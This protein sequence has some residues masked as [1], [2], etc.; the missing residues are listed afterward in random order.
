MHQ[1]RIVI[2]APAPEPVG[3]LCAALTA[4]GVRCT[5]RRILGTQ[6]CRVHAVA[7]P[8]AGIVYRADPPFRIPPPVNALRCTA[9]THKGHRCKLYRALVG[10]GGDLFCAAHARGGARV[11]RAVPIGDVGRFAADTQNVHTRE[12]AEMV[13]R[14]AAE[15]VERATTMK[16]I[17][18]AF[19]KL[20]ASKHRHRRVTVLADMREW[21]GKS[22]VRK[23]GDWA[24]RR[25]L[26][27]VWTKIV[28]HRE[29][30]ELV[31]RLWQEAEEAVGY[32]ADGHIG[33]LAN[34]LQGYDEDAPPPPK[35]S[36]NEML[37]MRFPAVA[38]L[39]LGQRRAA[40]RALLEEVGLP[41]EEWGVWME[42]AGLEE[43]P[44]AEELAARGVVH[45]AVRRVVA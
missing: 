34:V 6:H 35:L 26:D 32:C 25:M 16:E 2:A 37:Q 4:A 22:L 41:K 1:P 29:R 10:M 24:Y 15:T 38:A 8:P 9:A 27:A 7:P 21:Y 20:E 3:N 40:A 17:E 28:A 39:E 19:G 44:A 18:E 42:A 13:N 45:R 11:G 31:K 14:V 36:P 5:H 43:A 33:R 23:A 12:V 30:D